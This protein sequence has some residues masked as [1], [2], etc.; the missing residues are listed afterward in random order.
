MQ[1]MQ[2]PPAA[3]Q[4]GS[5]HKSQGLALYGRSSRHTQPSHLGARAT[6]ASAFACR[7]DGNCR[8][9]PRAP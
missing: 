4:G 9:A 5:A 8:G 2:L 3:G 7:A 6:A 1:G